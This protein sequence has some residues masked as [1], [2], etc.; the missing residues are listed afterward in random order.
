MRNLIAAIDLGTTKVVC[1][2]GEKTAAGIKIIALSEAPSKGVSRGEVVNIQSVLDSM[3]P[4]IRNVENA[5]GEKINEVFVGIAGQNIRCEQGTDQTIRINPDELITSKEI[6]EITRKMYGTFCQGG[7]EVLHAIPQSYIVDDHMGITE[8]VGMP[9]KQIF[10]NF[11]LFIGKKTSAQFSNNVIARADLK[12]KELIL[13]PLASAKAVLGEDEME[14]GVAMLDIGGGTSDLLIIQDNII[15]HT[16]IIPFGGNCI[17]DDVKQGCGVSS[18]IA[19]QL[20]TDHGSCMSSLAQENKR[21]VIP[22]VGGREN[23]EISL[24]H[25]AGII[26]ARVEEILEAALYEIEKSGYKN[27]IKAGLVITG[28]TSQLANI[29]QLANIVT[30][31]ETRLAYPGREFCDTEAQV[32][33]PSLSTAV[34]LVLMGF[35]KMEHEGVRYNTTTPINYLQEQEEETVLVEAA[36]QEQEAAAQETAAQDAAPVQK[37]EPKKKSWSLKG[38]FSQFNEDKM[39]TDNE[40]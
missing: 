29:R 36:V 3:L 1:L 26:E 40:A 30:G 25:I 2:V 18:K 22:G 39:F 27:K 11:K 13:E 17:T 34:G 6:D 21:V 20:K 9:G 5:I 10:S 24:K 38:F 14:I 35:E 33:K 16:A 31:L 12:L 8:P 19:E 4:T 37:Q 32:C 23:K 7:E 28:G 15:R